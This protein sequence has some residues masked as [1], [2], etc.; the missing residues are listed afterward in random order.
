MGLNW[1]VIHFLP[2][3]ATLYSSTL[4]STVQSV[5]QTVAKLK[6]HWL[7][8]SMRNWYTFPLIWFNPIWIYIFVDARH[9]WNS[10]AQKETALDITSKIMDSTYDHTSSSSTVLVLLRKLWIQSALIHSYRWISVKNATRVKLTLKPIWGSRFIGGQS[11][12]NS[13]KPTS[14]RPT[15]KLTLVMIW[16]KSGVDLSLSNSTWS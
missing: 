15:G 10:L 8:P 5:V 14:Q 16:E 11:C 6:K 4:G 2:S 12:V 3:M 13:Q 1:L 7:L 9:S